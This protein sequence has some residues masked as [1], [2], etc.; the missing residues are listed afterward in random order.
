MIHLIS[1]DTDEGAISSPIGRV[2]LTETG[3]AFAG[4]DASRYASL[5]Q[6]LAAVGRCLD[7]RVT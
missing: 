5:E 3:W 4:E 1:I 2:T 7:S 6:V